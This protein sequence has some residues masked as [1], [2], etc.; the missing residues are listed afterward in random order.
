MSDGS[1]KTSYYGEQNAIIKMNVKIIGLQ[2]NGEPITYFNDDISRSQKIKG[3]TM[4]NE[5][6]AEKSLLQEYAKIRK[7]FIEKFHKVYLQEELNRLL[8]FTEEMKMTKFFTIKKF[9]KFDYSDFNEAQQ[10]AISAMK[11]LDSDITNLSGYKSAIQPAINIWN[12]ALEESDLNAKKT[13]VND[14]VTCAAYLNIAKANFILQEYEVALDYINK[15]KEIDK[16][17]KGVDY[18]KR[19]VERNLKLKKNYIE[20]NNTPDYQS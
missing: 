9:K 13:R 20:K 19:D 5:K 12:K 4:G 1:R 15:L 11:T 6:A 16:S 7:S 14:K 18:L 17:F 10:I 8:I 2:E 3:K